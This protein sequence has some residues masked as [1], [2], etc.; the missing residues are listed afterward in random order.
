MERDEVDAGFWPEDDDGEPELS[1]LAMTRHTAPTATILRTLQ[2][3]IRRSGSTVNASTQTEQL[4]G[5]APTSDDLHGNTAARPENRSKS[6]V[7]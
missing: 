7:V 6:T 2:Y 1:Q 5:C 4:V 3:R